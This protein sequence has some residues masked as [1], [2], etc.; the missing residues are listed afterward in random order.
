VGDSWC[1]LRSDFR[2]EDERGLGAPVEQRHRAGGKWAP[3]VG[4]L[5]VDDELAGAGRDDVLGRDADVGGF[6]DRPG[7]RVLALARRAEADLLG[8]DPERDLAR[9]AA[10][11]DAQLVARLDA[12]AI[13]C[14]DRAAQQVRDA[15]EV[16]DE[17]GRGRS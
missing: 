4:V 12:D 2:V 16:R 13:R 3:P 10:E 17:G 11:R 14:S 6:L 1:L 15:E 8:A 5:R 7:E 9:T